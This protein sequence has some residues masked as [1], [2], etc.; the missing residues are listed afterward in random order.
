MVIQADL[1]NAEIIRG[2]PHSRGKGS[3]CWRQAVQ[4]MVRLWWYMHR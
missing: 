2:K 4:N 1:Q 3:T